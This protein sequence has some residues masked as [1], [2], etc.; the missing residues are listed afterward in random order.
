MQKLKHFGHI[1]LFELNRG[2]KAA[3]A[4]RNICAIYGDND[5]E[6]NMVRKLFSRFKVDRF[7]ISDTPHS[8][9]PLGFDENCLNTLIHNDHSSTGK[10]DEL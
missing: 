8:G 3:E 6:E 7:D 4:A 10:C 9:T 1:L 5:I 2:T